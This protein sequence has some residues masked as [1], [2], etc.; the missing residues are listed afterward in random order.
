MVDLVD[1]FPRPKNANVVTK[2]PTQSVFREAK[3]VQEELKRWLVRRVEC[4]RGQL[5]LGQN[6]CLRS[7]RQVQASLTPAQMLRS[8]PR[9]TMRGRST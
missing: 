8:S 9:L 5:T 4:I 7:D 6:L 2:G 1:F 3:S